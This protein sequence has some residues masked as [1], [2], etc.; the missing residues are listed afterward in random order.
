MRPGTGIVRTANNATDMQGNKK[1]VLIVD[2]DVDFQFM[3]TTMLKLNGFAIKSLIEG[4]LTPTVDSAKM[5][6]IVLLDIELPGTNGVDIARRL[7]SLPQTEKIPIILLSGHA[8]CERLFLE[9]R[10]NAFFK[11]PFSL[12]Q[13]LSKIKE[14]LELDS[15]SLP[16]SVLVVDQTSMNVQPLTASGKRLI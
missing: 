7:K 16:D 3:I 12:R 4:H 14:L 2:D 9:S 13:V 10:A 5:C 11:K 15:T 1:T 8:E 6:D